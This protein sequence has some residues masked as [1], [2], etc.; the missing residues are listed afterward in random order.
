MP[1]A[2]LVLQ[3]WKGWDEG[4]DT[5][6][7]NLGHPFSYEH[8]LFGDAWFIGGDV[9]FGPFRL[10]PAV[11][12]HNRAYEQPTAFLRITYKKMPETLSRI[13]AD[14]EAVIQELNTS[15]DT[16][17]YHGGDLKDEIAAL[18]GLAVGG[19]FEAGPAI[20]RS[21]RGDS[22][23]WTTP[24]ITWRPV[25]RGGARD[26]L[27]FTLGA[28]RTDDLELLKRLKGLDPEPLRELVRS[29]RQRQVALQLVT[30]EPALSWLLLWFAVETVA[31]YW[32]SGPPC[33]KQRGDVGK[34]VPDFIKKFAPSQPPDRPHPNA[35]IEW[36]ELS[37]LMK[38][39]YKHRNAAL[40]DGIPFPSPMWQTPAPQHEEWAAPEERPTGAIS[41][42]ARWSPEDM[43]LHLHVFEYVVRGS[44]KKWWEAN[45]PRKATE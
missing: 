5:N 20:R 14:P 45:C 19:A 31:A 39:V 29:A 44:I 4:T 8:A 9:E 41:E 38:V 37:E 35:Q 26:P 3:C 43:A 34:R 36:T 2:P 33:G 23:D 17:A 7:A 10:I 21:R 12:D 27:F 6:S 25:P 22:H 30:H 42:L 28:R 40:H 24:Y 18:A 16:S 15:S 11:R 1:E 32:L 13:K